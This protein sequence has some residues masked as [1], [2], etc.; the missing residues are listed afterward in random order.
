MLA[1]AAAMFLIKPVYRLQQLA[2]K[3]SPT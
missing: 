3:D 2:A 1:C